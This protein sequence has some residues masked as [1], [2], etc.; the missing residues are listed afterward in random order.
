M[1]V[2]RWLLVAVCVRLFAVWSSSSCVG[3]CLLYVVSCLCVW[4]LVF[5]VCYELCVACCWLFVG[6]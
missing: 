6:G 3:C 4:C 5:G 1:R 2:A